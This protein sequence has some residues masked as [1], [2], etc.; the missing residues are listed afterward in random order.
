M[1][2]SY[3]RILVA[4]IGPDLAVSRTRH[5]TSGTQNLTSEIRQLSHRFQK[6]FVTS[7]VLM[8]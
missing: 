3:T 1:T 8:A 5:L 2:E 6:S 4:L 7:D